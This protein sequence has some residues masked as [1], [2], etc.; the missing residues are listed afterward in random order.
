MKYLIELKNV[1]D[2]KY[3]C[4]GQKLMNYEII[5]IDTIRGIIYL[6]LMTDKDLK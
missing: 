6:E 2:V 3:F 5:M 1:K 4:C